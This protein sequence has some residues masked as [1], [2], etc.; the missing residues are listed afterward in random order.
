MRTE[1]LMT[2]S[3]NIRPELEERLSARAR[4]IG[5]SLEGYIQHILE[6]EAATSTKD[7]PL[8]LTGIERAEAFEAWAKSFPPNLPALSLESISRE[9][10]YQRD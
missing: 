1:A 2:V 9:N 6:H 8:S 7:E 5:Q 10:I 3:L 4:L